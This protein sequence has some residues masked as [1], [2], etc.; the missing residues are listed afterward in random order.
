MSIKYSPWS[1]EIAIY[2]PETLGISSS[3]SRRSSASTISSSSRVSNISTTSNNS[4]GSN[5]SSISSTSP[6]ISSSSIEPTSISKSIYFDYNNAPLT[7]KYSVSDNRI[8]NVNQGI[9]IYYT[10]NST[11]KGGI[12]SPGIMFPTFTMS[13]TRNP[14]LN[15]TFQEVKTFD[16][17]N[18][19]AHPIISEK[20]INNENVDIT[21][22]G[23]ENS[24]FNMSL[25]ALFVG[26]GRLKNSINTY[27]GGLNNFINI[28]GI[29]FGS[30]E[31][32]K[33]PL[34][35]IYKNF[36]LP[37]LCNLAQTI[38]NSSVFTMNLDLKS[39]LIGNPSRLPA[40]FD[41]IHENCS[42]SGYSEPFL[43]KN[44]NIKFKTINRPIWGNTLTRIGILDENKIYQK[45]KNW[46]WPK[47]NTNWHN[48]K[49]D[50]TT[51]DINN[52]TFIVN[53][54]P[55]LVYPGLKW[56][57][58]NVDSDLSNLNQY[59]YSHDY[60][61]NS[62]GSPTGIEIKTNYGITSSDN[63]PFV[64]YINYKPYVLGM[65]SD[66]VENH[67]YYGCKLKIE[68]S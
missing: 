45:D 67:P 7:Q 61:N 54:T 26:S 32:T 29:S 38:S 18:V 15:E 11:T 12:K 1:N 68:R 30:P 34:L 9:D 20:F 24:N 22:T 14:L 55:S 8:N 6:G 33:G 19:F 37:N 59:L 47:N 52:N 10:G 43:N 58:S 49:L 63:T 50:V 23:I 13:L 35:S 57:F 60:L 42:I 44:I 62:D 48:L 56:R 2:V 64:G 66:I 51:A 39:K 27:D 41:V 53:C 16:A 4:A 40:P 46:G 5:N 36:P 25:L 28:S 3:S 65:T 31:N 17:P 21:L